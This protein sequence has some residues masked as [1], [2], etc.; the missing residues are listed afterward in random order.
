MKPREY[1]CYDCGTVRE[2]FVPDLE[3]FPEF[4]PCYECEGQAKKT[5]TPM[6]TICHQGKAGNYKNGY[7]SNPVKIKKT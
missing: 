4:I 3:E 7:S 1:K 5:F 6:H 2:I